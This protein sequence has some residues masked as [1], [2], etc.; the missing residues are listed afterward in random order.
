M[1]IGAGP[2]CHADVVSATAK[3]RDREA[4]AEGHALAHVRDLALRER[5]IVTIGNR[6]LTVG[7]ARSG[8]VRTAIDLGAH[9]ACATAAGAAAASTTAAA[10]ASTT[11]ASTT[12]AST[13]A[14]STTASRAGFGTTGTAAA[15]TRRTSTHAG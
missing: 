8:V 12:A 10:A 2:R 13:T 1:R 3:L 7:S 5:M 11:A 4:H 6:V 14:A 15:A 9:R